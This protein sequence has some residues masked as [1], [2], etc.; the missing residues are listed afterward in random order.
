MTA[1]TNR[2]SRSSWFIL[3]LALVLAV[4]LSAPAGAVVDDVLRTA[5]C[6][7]LLDG[8]ADLAGDEL[9]TLADPTYC[10]AQ[11]DTTFCAPSGTACSTQA[12]EQ[13]ADGS[14]AVEV[15]GV[16]DPGGVMALAVGRTGQTH[17]CGQP[18]YVQA[19]IRF[20]SEGV[21][22]LVATHR[23]SKSLDHATTQNGA[24]NIGVCYQSPK[25][26]TDRD[27]ATVMSGL[28]PTCDAVGDAA[29]CI[30]HRRKNRADAVVA[31]RLPFGDPT[32][33][34][35]EDFIDERTG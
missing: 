3:G 13:T 14:V 12:E 2:H 24:D 4:G 27:G 30:L 15:T 21:R 17:A 25:P 35:V 16:A 31:L 34:M 22:D 18:L 7:G 1:R 28:L 33:K 23:V 32:W 6:T 29:P 8:V 10:H 5:T 26:F 19:A 11:S 9:E 20:E